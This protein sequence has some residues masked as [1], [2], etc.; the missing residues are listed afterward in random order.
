MAGKDEGAD[1]N[2]VKDVQAE[3]NGH[4]SMLLKI[5]RIG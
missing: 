1:M 3:L 5:W 2:T 4:I